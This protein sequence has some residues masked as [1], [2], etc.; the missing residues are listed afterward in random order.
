MH[1]MAHQYEEEMDRATGGSVDN[2]STTA[3]RAG[4]VML[5]LVN[6]C[7]PRTSELLEQTSQDSLKNQLTR[8]TGSFRPYQKRPL[9]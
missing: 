8:T 6:G 3:T 9:D 2:Q 1:P 5:E 4:L 7:E